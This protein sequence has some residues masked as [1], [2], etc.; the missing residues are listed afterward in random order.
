MTSTLSSSR[1][2]LAHWLPVFT[3]PLPKNVNYVLPFDGTKAGLKNNGVKVQNN[4]TE[5]LFANIFEKV[6]F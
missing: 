2:N 1:V 4:K 3:N 6:L 5:S